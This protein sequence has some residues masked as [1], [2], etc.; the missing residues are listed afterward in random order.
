[1]ETHAHIAIVRGQT[2]WGAH[3]T[4]YVRFPYRSEE[5]SLPILYDD[6]EA[7]YVP[8]DK[9]MVSLSDEAD[10]CA[11]A[12][13]T[14]QPDSRLVGVGIDLASRDDFGPRPGTE[15]FIKLIFSDRERELAQQISPRDL[16][17]AYAVLFGAKEA[18]FKA[19]ARALRMWYS[20]HTEPLE[21]EV[22][23]FGMVDI[24]LVRGELRRGAAQ[25]ALDLMGIECIAVTY[26]RLDNMALV[27]AG[28]Y[29]AT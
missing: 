10:Y 14:E 8:G 27:V 5:V 16:P 3:N 17:Y 12:W 9:T 28:A 24:S 15:R 1:M 4:G 11:C 22:R 21:Y 6:R 23:D 7:P 29:A 13:K 19:T 2:S 26:Q 25:R 20:E 18:A